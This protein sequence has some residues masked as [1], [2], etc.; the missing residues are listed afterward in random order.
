MLLNT[1]FIWPRIYIKAITFLSLA[2]SGV[3]LLQEM[4]PQG[5]T[6]ANIRYRK[7]SCCLCSSH[8]QSFPTDQRDSRIPYA[9]SNTSPMPQTDVKSCFNEKAFFKPCEARKTAWVFLRLGLDVLFQATSTT[10]VWFRGT[11]QFQRSGLKIAHGTIMKNTTFAPKGSCWKGTQRPRG[12][13]FVLRHKPGPRR[14]SC[15]STIGTGTSSSTQHT[16]SREEAA[17]TPPRGSGKEKATAKSMCV[18][19]VQPS[20]RQKTIP[21]LTVKTSTFG[22][23]EI[24]PKCQKGG[25]RTAMEGTSQCQSRHHHGKPDFDQEPSMERADHALLSLN[26]SLQGLYI[27][28][29]SRIISMATIWRTY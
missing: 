10:Q 15:G 13:R 20:A 6:L 22:T 4:L 8:T 12:S 14:G 9:A 7:M 3:L 1:L 23:I 19:M 16:S 18:P 26:Q 5:I 24:C 28:S 25:T 21:N 27:L 11:K 29:E 17:Q 2:A